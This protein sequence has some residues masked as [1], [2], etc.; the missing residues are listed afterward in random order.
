MD[1]GD[2]N[3]IISG[4]MAEASDTGKVPLRDWK[5]RVTN[6]AMAPIGSKSYGQARMLLPYSL[7]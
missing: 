4:Y 6:K 5:D 2:P 3:K 1:D 7:A